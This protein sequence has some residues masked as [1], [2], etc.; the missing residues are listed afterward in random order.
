MLARL[1][2]VSLAVAFGAVAG[3]PAAALPG[4]FG[5]PNLDGSWI[6]GD[7]ALGFTFIHPFLVG[8]PPAYP[9]SVLPT[10]RLEAGWRDWLAVGANYATKTLTVPGASQELEVFAR[11][12]VLSEEAGA[13]IGLGLGEAFNVTSMSLDA[14]ITADRAI[15]P[16]DVAVV[17][18]AMSNYRYTGVPRVALGLGLAWRSPWGLDLAAD[19]LTSPMRGPTEPPLVWGLG[20]RGQVPWSPHTLTLLATNGGTATLQGASTPAADVRYGFA[21]TIPLRPL[22][23]AVVPATSR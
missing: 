13:P 23:A 19:A 8:A 3:E 12:R 15:G 22:W 2:I 7:G 20:L 6:P 1:R 16:L 18:R 9:V 4:P 14:E 5:A 10:F 11:Q 17:A 21:F